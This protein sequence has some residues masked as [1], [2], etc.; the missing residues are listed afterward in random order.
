MFN[1]LKEITTKAS[2]AMGLTYRQRFGKLFGLLV[3]IYLSSLYSKTLTG[4]RKTTVG[5]FFPFIGS[6]IDILTAKTLG[7]G[8]YGGRSPITVMQISQN[9][10]KGS[11]DFIKYGDTK[12]LRK[13]GI[14]FGLALG[15]FGGGSQINNVIDGITA[16]IDEDVRNVKGNVMF[17]V[18]D[19][20]SKVIAP[21]FGVWATKEGREYFEPKKPAEL[22]IPKRP[23]GIKSLVR[24]IRKSRKF[25]F[26]D[27]L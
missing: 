10:I 14:N 20:I 19:T 12:K 5:T 16:N 2:G 11:R 18:E 25:V 7:K 4:R 8:Y 17:S 22:F 13:A 6:Y 1:H 21:I 26:P 9:V 24:P 3:G 27:E 23:K 15:G